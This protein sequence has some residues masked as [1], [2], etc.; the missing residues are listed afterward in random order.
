MTDNSKEHKNSIDLDDKDKNIL[1]HLQKNADIPLEKI[2]EKTGLSKTA[3]WNRLQKLR[4]DGIILGQVLL[5]DPKKIGLTETFF[6]HIKTDQHNAD[7]FINFQQTIK[8]MP[9]IIEAHRLAGM[10]D[11]LLKVQVASTREFDEFYKE[12]VSQ[13]NLSD[14]TSNLS[15][16]TMKYSTVLPL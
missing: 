9:Q 13:I 7:W 6:V 1:Y 4:Q 15:M 3:V 11:Y 2:A 14:V 10:Y 16:E 5:L 8:K 12:L